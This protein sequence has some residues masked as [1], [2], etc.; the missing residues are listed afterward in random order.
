MGTVQSAEAGT[1]QA[2]GRGEPHLIIHYVTPS[3]PRMSLGLTIKFLGTVADLFLPWI[4]AYMI[5]T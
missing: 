1:T 4:L 5:D 2:S 3:L